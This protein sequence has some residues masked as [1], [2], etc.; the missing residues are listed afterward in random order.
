VPVDDDAGDDVELA[1]VELAAAFEVACSDGAEFL[2]PSRGEL[3]EPPRAI[4]IAAIV[5]TT[6]AMTANRRRAPVDIAAW[7]RT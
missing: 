7:S 2:A 6:I 4:A 1:V 3:L 5:A